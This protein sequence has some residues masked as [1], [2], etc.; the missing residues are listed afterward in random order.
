MFMSRR[1]SFGFAIG[2]EMIGGLIG[3]TGVVLLIL[4][5]QGLGDGFAEALDLVLPCLAVQ[6]KKIDSGDIEH[7][8]S[9]K[10]NR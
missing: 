2:V 4:G 8:E 6:K 1:L 3:M 7:S 5:S 10:V 9:K